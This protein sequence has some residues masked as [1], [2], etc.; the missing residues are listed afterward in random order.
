VREANG[1]GHSF[2][3]ALAMGALILVWI[4]LLATNQTD[5]AVQAIR[6]WLPHWFPVL[7][8]FLAPLF[9][10]FAGAAIRISPGLRLA[11]VVLMLCSFS[12]LY[13][14]Y[15][16]HPVAYMSA[17]VVIMLELFLIIPKWNERHRNTATR[18]EGR[19]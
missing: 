10:A 15:A 16:N 13:L 8:L 7:N 12:A 19:R 18:Q 3:I 9:A 2:L 14:S 1:P 6:G 4:A 5:R 17:L 11:A